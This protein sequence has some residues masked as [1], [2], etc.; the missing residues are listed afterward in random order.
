MNES[1]PPQKAIH[2][3]GSHEDSPGRLSIFQ[4]RRI[5]ESFED[6]Y[7]EIDLQENIRILSPSCY[8]LTGWKPEELIG[9]PVRNVYVDPRERDRILAI[10]TRDGFAD[11]FVTLLRRKDGTSIPAS[12]NARLIVD[13]HGLP[14]GVAGTIRDITKVLATEERLKESEL[15]FRTLAE[16]SPFAIMIY[17]D[18]RWLYANPAAEQISGYRLEELV[19]KTFW[20]FVHP[21]DKGLVRARGQARQR[22]EN[23]RNVYEIRIIDKQGNIKWVLLTGVTIQ[24]GGKAAGLISAID[25]TERK[26]A[27]QDR[28]NYREQ[29]NRS[30]KMESVGLLAGG[31]AH[32]LNNLL[33][34]M[35]GY[36]ELLLL[37]P[38]LD[39]KARRYVQKFMETSEKAKDLV[40]RLM[41]F[42]MNQQ[43]IIHPVNLNRIIRDFI[44]LISRSLREDIRIIT[45]LNEQIPRIMADPGQVEQVIMNLAVNAQDAMPNGGTL[46]LRTQPAD[47]SETGFLP[48]D[49]KIG[50]SA[51]RMTVC[52]TGIG[53]D[54]ETCARIFDPFFTTK[55][56]GKGTGLGLAMVY[57]IITQHGGRVRVRSEIGKGAVFDIDWPAAMDG[58]MPTRVVHPELQDLAGGTETILLSEDDDA[59][60]EFAISLME[61]LGYR[62]L[63]AS[64]PQE[65]LELLQSHRSA[66][67]LLTDVIMPDM[68]GK[69][70]YW[71]A[72]KLCPDIRVLYMSGHPEET[73]RRN[74]IL[75]EN[76]SLIQKPFTLD[77]LARKIREVLAAPHP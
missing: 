20:D 43:L 41:A 73:V 62:V 55:E 22:G 31:I 60:R 77:S 51:V 42:G 6:L 46:I 66:D 38:E 50:Q 74:G 58:E 3:D 52:D 24:Y 25:I 17:Q 47:T 64:S 69:T 4:Y 65:C 48:K 68:S 36:C 32:D 40:R 49:A 16:A 53:M 29:L 10:L 27:E 33:Q 2:D 37:N 14:D 34:P 44:G 1:L 61:R 72:V 21:D 5:F 19:G 56:M 70:L 9:K 28:E 39:E 76:D 57:G 45:D 18:N 30:Q 54:P 12:I 75:T 7:Y 23:P 13:E 71:N 67:L 59:V 63:S 26:T 11:N 35:M 8:R 15:K